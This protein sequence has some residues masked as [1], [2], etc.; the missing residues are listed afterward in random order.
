[1]KPVGARIGKDC[2]QSCQDAGICDLRSSEREKAQLL[3]KERCYARTAAISWRERKPL[4]RPACKKRQEV[5]AGV[6]AGQSGPQQ[7]LPSA[8]IAR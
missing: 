1:M 7:G 6:I 8:S 2:C 5:V 4:H 3:V